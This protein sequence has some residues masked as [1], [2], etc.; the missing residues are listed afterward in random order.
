[1]KNSKK[2][3]AIA[4]NNG[5]VARTHMDTMVKPHKV[6]TRS[7]S[8]DS[9]D[10]NAT[11]SLRM[12]GYTLQ[13]LSEQGNRDRVSII[14]PDSI[15]LR[16]A[17]AFKN[18]KAGL[19]ADSMMLDWMYDYEKHPEYQIEDGN[20]EAVNIWERALGEF[21]GA[22]EDVMTNARYQVNI[23][24]RHQLTLWEIFTG[25]KKNGAHT[26]NGLEAGQKV[27]FAN[28]IGH[29][30]DEDGNIIPEYT[31]KSENNILSGEYEAKESH[32]KMYVDRKVYRDENGKVAGASSKALM[33]A[34]AV[35]EAC[36]A[37]LPQID[38]DDDEEILVE[39]EPT[40]VAV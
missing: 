38:Y 28:G 21:Y 27:S 37:L 35:N 36:N 33:L 31:V 39:E 11:M 18:I 22:L 3:F 25:T 15:N 14:V 19:D 30:L 16:V 34:R 9:G 26:Y 24:P 12:L 29:I 13:Q 2:I 10:T 6:L 4:S 32:G 5:I 8:V 17:Q 1:M 7:A 20:G 23:V 40:A